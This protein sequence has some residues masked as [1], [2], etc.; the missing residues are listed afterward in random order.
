MLRLE[1]KEDLKLENYQIE[2]YEKLKLIGEE[3]ASFYLDGIKI[4]K[5]RCFQT[6]PYLLGHI[7]R[8]I[9][10]GIRDIWASPYRISPYCRKKLNKDQEKCKC[11]KYKKPKH[12]EEIAKILNLDPKHPFVERWYKIAKNFH[13]FAH[14]HGV[15]KEVRSEK[16]MN[17]FWKNFEREI[18]YRF[19]GRFIHLLEQVEKLLE[20]SKPTK[21]ILSTLEN[22]LKNKAVANYFFKKLNHI[23]WFPF[24]KEKGFF[25]PEKAPGPEPTDED[26]YYTFP[27]WN[28]LDYLERISKKVNEPGNETYIKPLLD[29][30]K[31]VTEY[32]KQTKKLD[33]YRIWRSFI[34]ILSNLPPDKI[35]MDIIDLIPI[36]LDSKFNND[37][38]VLKI[39]E[40]FFPKFLTDNPDDIKKAEKIIEY[41]TE[42]QGKDKNKHFKANIYLLKEFFKEHLNNIA[43]KCTTKVIKILTKRIKEA[44]TTEYEGTLCSLYKYEENLLLERPV[45]LL[46]YV[47]SKILLIK[48]EKE[49]ESI[50]NILESFFEKQ[51]P[52]FSKI[53]LFV[54]GQHMDTFKELF[55]QH[56][57][58]KGE[59]ILEGTRLFWGDEL[60]RI[61]ENLGPLDNIQQKI[62]KEKI[63]I[64]AENYANTL[65]D[66]D[67]KEK[68]KWPIFF[69]Q[70]FYN[71]LS[72]CEEF[73][74]LYEEAKII[75][76]VDAELRPAIRIS[77]TKI[78]HSRSPLTTDQILNM[79]NM[80]LADYLI[81]LKINSPS[82]RD[83]SEDLAE[84]LRMAVK[85]AP[86]K[87]AQDLKPFLKTGYLYVEKM[88]Q[89]FREALQEDK[90]IQ[91]EKLF[92]FFGNYIAQK[93]FWEDKFK[94]QSSL[95]ATY[96]WVI[97]SFYVFLR[98]ALQ[99]RDYPIS[100]TLFE[101][102]EF[103]IHLTLDNL[104][105][106]LNSKPD[107]EIL[108]Y[109]V[110]SINTPIGHT[111]E[112]YINFVLKVLQS[113][114]DKKEFVKYSFIKKYK[115]LLSKQFI[116]A[117]TLFGMYFLN[118]YFHIDK[119]FTIKIAQS[120]KKG[121]EIWEAFMQG[122][123]FIGHIDKDIYNLMKE[124]Y[125]F[126]LNYS[127]KDSSSREHLIQH[128]SL[129]YLIGL[130]SLD[131]PSLFNILIEKFDPDDINQIIRFFWGQRDYLEKDNERDKQIKKKILD[132]WQVVYKKLEKKEKEGKL[133]KEE[134]GILSNLF[135]LIVFLP[136]LKEPYDQWLKI[137]VKYLRYYGSIFLDDLERFID[138]GDRIK[139]AKIIGEILLKAPVFTYSKDKIKSFIEYL[140]KINDKKVKDTARKICNKYIEQIQDTDF[141]KEIM[142]IHQKCN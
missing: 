89:G 110:Y 77:K 84:T 96:E 24:L 100:V 6:K 3:I 48:A 31:E 37:L 137:S 114:Y 9:E 112:V 57:K 79:N 124:H 115:E 99:N 74:D 12:R 128:I 103:I 45:E 10:S 83:I 2:I 68:E 82:E 13:R 25:S 26:G 28:V 139:T 123:F 85:T 135:N 127:F 113:S 43:E 80:A 63:D 69:K 104:L 33:N 101:K 39:K 130:E 133:S 94:V 60:K 62:L 73:K 4:F 40:K 41:L 11:G 109:P 23:K 52:I 119:N 44:I 61:L 86:E 125:T 66:K 132:F 55:W 32:H 17:E 1:K 46:A 106:N 97:N 134:K 105:K 142:Q 75:T 116:E 108:D 98:K 64:A 78:A 18:L 129:A 29:I 71:A 56:F 30:I 111:I 59:K 67:E 140:C 54:I 91:Y 16:K 81:H 14:R 19:I 70:K 141:V 36:W 90:P 49:P 117:F 35:P 87:F 27:F 21:E 93:E 138:S 76:K 53:A 20:P 72:F 118:F 22:L 88:F 95:P 120:L 7:A 126:A 58:D 51:H 8:E 65:K 92:D 121:G 131:T 122:Y 15:W 102:I 5:S 47:L 42:I 136:E 34:I 107:E 50:K 38:Q